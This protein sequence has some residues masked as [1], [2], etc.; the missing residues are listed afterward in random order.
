M[1]G[2]REF[3]PR[4]AALPV[5]PAIDQDKSDPDKYAQ[6]GFDYKQALKDGAIVLKNGGKPTLFKIM[7][8]E[9]KQR[10]VVA[11]FHDDNESAIE[12]ADYL[13]RAGLL[14]IKDWQVYKLNGDVDEK[15]WELER[16]DYNRHGTC[17]SLEDAQNLPLRM[18]HVIMLAN[19]IWKVSE[20]DPFEQTPSEPQSG[21][22]E[23]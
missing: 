8:I 4:W 5:D 2:H 13:L 7:P 22:T 3:E 18:T 23:Q 11:S 20:T 9:S 10:R 1:L 14:A 16:R 21:H 17:C 19:M 6:L 15:H 12:R